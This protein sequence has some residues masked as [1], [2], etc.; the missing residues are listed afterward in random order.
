MEKIEFIAPNGVKVKG[1]V[2][3]RVNYELTASLTAVGVIIVY[4]QNRIAEVRVEQDLDGNTTTAV[5][6]LV[7]YA[8]IPELD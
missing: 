5:K 8:V 3:D 7:E 2:L 1:T 4:A 6:I